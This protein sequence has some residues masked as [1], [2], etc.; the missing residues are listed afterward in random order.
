VIEFLAI[1]TAV[2]PIRADHVIQPPVMV[3]T[4]DH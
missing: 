3:L 2:R 4:L 1:G